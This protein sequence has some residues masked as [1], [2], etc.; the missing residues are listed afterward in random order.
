MKNPALVLNVNAPIQMIMTQVFQT[1]IAPEI[2]EY[3]GLR[4]SQ[5]NN[6]ELCISQSLLKGE[7]NPAMQERLEHVLGWRKSD[8]FTAAEKSA[9]ELAEAITVLKDRYN[10]VSDELWS[11]VETYYNEKEKAALVLF[12]SIMNMFTRMNVATKQVT[13][14]W[15]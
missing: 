14:D 15:A 8:K 1:G 4:V 10:S 11:G 7:G 6:C 12:I 9:L 2:L 13:A 5:I 3:V